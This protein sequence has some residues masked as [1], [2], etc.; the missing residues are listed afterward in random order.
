[1]FDDID[2][3]RLRDYQS[4]RKD[5]A[6]D[7]GDIVNSC[8]SKS[9]SLLKLCSIFQ[10]FI[11]WDAVNEFF[12]SKNIRKQFKAAQFTPSFFSLLC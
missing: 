6:S 2:M 7:K 8:G 9:V 12:T 11:L 10:V 1:M 5:G 4:H 3:Q